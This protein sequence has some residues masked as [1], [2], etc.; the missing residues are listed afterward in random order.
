MIAEL[1]HLSKI[2]LHCTRNWLVDSRRFPV[3]MLVLLRS[4]LR[5]YSSRR[6]FAFSRYALRCVLQVSEV[7]ADH[8]GKKLLVTISLMVP[9]DRTPE[10]GPFSICGASTDTSRTSRHLS[11]GDIGCQE[12]SGIRNCYSAS[13]TE[14]P[15][16]R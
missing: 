4:P 11:S 9:I 2:A 15:C 10:N 12:L 1:C 16:K 14:P 6:I 7:F 8:V 3:G 5:N 13:F